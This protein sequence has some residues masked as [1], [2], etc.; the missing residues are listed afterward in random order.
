MRK[1]F[2]LF[3]ILSSI[4]SKRI[5]AQN[6]PPNIDFENGDFGSWQCSIGTTSLASNTQNVINLTPSA[7]QLG[8]HEIISSSTAPALDSYGNFPKLCPYG[9]AYSVKL[10]NNSVGAKAEGISYTFVV[11]ATLDTF[12]FT[13]FYAVVFEN[14]NHDIAEQPR[15]FVT[16][17]DVLTN[18][19]INCA[20]Y[21]YVASGSIPGFQV[22]T[23]DNTVLYKPWSPVSIQFAGLAGRTVRLEFKTAD[24]TIGGHFGYAYLD[25]GT[26]CSNIL[27]T[28]PYCVE[29]N[30]VILNAPFGFQTYTWYNSNFTTVVGNQQSITLSPP[31]AANNVFYVDVIPYPG[32]GCRDTLQ[33]TVT[34]L[35]VPDTP[36]VAN[37]F[38]CQFQTVTPFNIIPLPNCELLWYTSAVGGIGTNIAPTINTSTIGTFNFYVSQKKLFGCE[39]LRKHITVIVTA[40]PLVSFII[41]NNKQC[42]N[43]NMFS[44]T[45]N[46]SFVQSGAT[47]TWTFGDGQTSTAGPIVTHTYANAGQYNVKLRIEN[48]TTCSGEKTVPVTVVPKPIADFTAPLTACENQTLLTVNNISSVPNNLSIITQ[49]WWSSN[50]VINAQQNLTPFIANVPG[51]F[52]IKLVVTSTEGCKSDTTT[53]SIN[54]HFKPTAV[55]TNS[56]PLCDN[57][58]IKFN[59]T[60]SLPSQASPDYIQKWNWTYNN[61]TTSSLQNPSMFFAQGA[62][63]IKLVVETDFGCKSDSI[64]KN[65]FINTAPK[66]QLSINDSCAKRNIIFNASDLTNTTTNW[67]WDF[68]NGQTILPATVNKNYLKETNFSLK[69]IAQNNFGCYDTLI[70]PIKIYGNKALA[71]LD[72]TAAI[73]QPVQLNANGYVG[74]TYLWT[75][76]LGL[77]N[78]TIE[79]PIAVLD[80]DQLYNL[81][82][83]TAEGC[84]S[85]SKIFIKRYKGPTIYIPSAFSPNG[86]GVN[87]LLHVTPVGYN[88]FEFFAVYNRFGQRL[89]YTTDYKKGWDG[90]FN[91]QKQDPAT[92]IAVAKAINYKGEIMLEKQTIILIR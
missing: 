61:T 84:D 36:V 21:N 40:A 66:A 2:F 83:T 1:C 76:N 67:L 30:S 70:R 7:P 75:P 28:A 56:I 92:Y 23:F 47:Y 48:N 12:S 44:F 4:F 16:A 29:T 87:D 88:K 6:C 78:N 3:L 57:N 58:L 9:G 35:P 82:S 52:P 45:S 8:R 62:L 68:G 69:L 72:L 86:D 65:I 74:S 34:A 38:Y 46:S 49:W 20:S 11:P 51:L 42:L 81:F 55:F 89:F 77:N 50:G 43:N 31:P 26:G 85:Y 80:K 64:I 15:F 37:R 53:K 5:I 13:Y 32:F 71:G 79:N 73:D 54:V 24:C 33:A 60:S 22:C 14:P 39:S 27:A 91:G 41:N 18:Q 59:N 10:G 17:Y 19:T 90:T 25:V 63:R